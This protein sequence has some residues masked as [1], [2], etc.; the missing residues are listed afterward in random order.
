MNLED[1]QILLEAKDLKRVFHTGEEDLTVLHELQLQVMQ[2]EF[3]AITGESGSG[4]ST[5]LHL[6]GCLDVPTSGSVHYMGRKLSSLDSSEQDHIRNREF[7]FVFQ[8]HHLLPEFNAMENVYLPGMI[9]R[10]PQNELQDQA[11]DI[12]TEL[13]MGHRLQHKPNQLSGGEQQRVAVARAMINSPKIL[14]MDEPTGNLDPANSEELV[15]II[16][17]QQ[18]GKHLTVVIVTH[19]PDIAHNSD[20]CLKL[21]DGRVVTD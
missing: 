3:L 6:L 9:A 2:S 1:K 13:G 12:L 18:K 7:G 16:R 20:R 19:D 17:E 21:R 10:R 11:K 14:F 15:A 5:L 8:F 4:K